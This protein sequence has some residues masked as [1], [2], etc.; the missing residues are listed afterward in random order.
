MAKNKTAY[1]CTECGADFTRWQGQCGECKEWNTITE[2][3]LGSVTP[4]KN[5]RYTG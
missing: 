2:V 5:A 4:G 1:V 3:R